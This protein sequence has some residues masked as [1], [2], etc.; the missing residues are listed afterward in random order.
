MHFTQRRNEIEAK[1]EDE[2]GWMGAPKRTQRH[3]AIEPWSGAIEELESQAARARAVL[4]FF[5]FIS[6]LISSWAMFIRL[7]VNTAAPMKASKRS[8]P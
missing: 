4:F 6:F 8:G 7:L 5:F 3:F 2:T 1:T